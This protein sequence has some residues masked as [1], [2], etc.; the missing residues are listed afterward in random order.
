VKASC[1]YVLKSY[2]WDSLNCLTW[3]DNAIS[4]T[5]M[6]SHMLQLELC[7]V[8]ADLEILYDRI[9][10]LKLLYN[11]HT[12]YGTKYPSTKHYIIKEVQ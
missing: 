11:L 3:Y 12:H 10:S 9:Y 8:T 2:L 5:V 4:I 1:N 7:N 6:W